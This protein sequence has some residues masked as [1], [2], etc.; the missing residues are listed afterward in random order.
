MRGGIEER[1][2]HRR[3]QRR[4]RPGP[5][6]DYVTVGESRGPTQATADSPGP[7]PDRDPAVT[8]PVLGSETLF[9]KFLNLLENLE[10]D[11][12]LGGCQHLLNLKDLL[13]H[14]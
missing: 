8:E 11:L 3:L 1:V 4:P 14:Q 9:A 10:D 2:D 13:V 5:V 12:D 7:S 6:P